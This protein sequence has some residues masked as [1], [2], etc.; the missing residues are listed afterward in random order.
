MYRPKSRKLTNDEYNALTKIAD[1]TKMDC[2]FH[3]VELDG[4]D[5]VEDLENGR[6]L[7][8]VDN[9]FR[10]FADGIVDPLAE[11]GLT[12]GE[13]KAVEALLKELEEE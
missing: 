5:Y 3:I 10:D 13:I 7:I 12:E 4:I 6:K 11:Y 9:A 2:W 1:A 8:G